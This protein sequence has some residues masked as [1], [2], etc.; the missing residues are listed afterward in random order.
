MITLG[1]KVKDKFTGFKG[2]AMAK[3]EYLFGCNRIG[4]QPIELDKETGE[5]K[6][7]VWFDEQHL[8]DEK[9]KKPGGPRPDAPNK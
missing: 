7:W 9:I 1:E 4:V 6:E 2:I 3:T 5:P 8:M